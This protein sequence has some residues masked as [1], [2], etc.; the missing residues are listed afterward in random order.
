MPL[1]FC[2]IFKHNGI[3]AFQM[4]LRMKNKYHLTF[5]SHPE[6]SE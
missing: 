1:G 3:S 5:K 6:E 4:T 2:K